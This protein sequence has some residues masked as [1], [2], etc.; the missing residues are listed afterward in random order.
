[1]IIILHIIICLKQ[2]APCH[3][4]DHHTTYYN[5]LKQWDND[6]RVPLA[7]DSLLCHQLEGDPLIRLQKH[8]YFLSV[9]ISFRKILLSLKMSFGKIL[10]SVKMSFRKILLSVKL[11]F[12]KILLSVK[13]SL[14][15][16]LGKLCSRSR[17]VSGNLDDSALPLPG[18]CRGR[19]AS[20]PD[21]VPGTIMHL[22]TDIAIRL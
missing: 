16:I 21:V 17:W 13:I 14:R 1:M 15:K 6:H 7:V 22:L 5:C 20:K 3:I 11:S 18:D 4:H 10:L 8:Q 2:L 12:R 9:K 19:F